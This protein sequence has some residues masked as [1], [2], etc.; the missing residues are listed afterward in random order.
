MKFLPT[1]WE[2][3]PNYTYYGKR[4]FTT[5]ILL[6]AFPY[7]YDVPVAKGILLR[8][9]Y[10]V[11]LLNKC[12]SLLTP[13]YLHILVTRSLWK[14]RGKPATCPEHPGEAAAATLEAR[15]PPPAPAKNPKANLW[16]IRDLQTST[17]ERIKAACQTSPDS[18]HTCMVQK[19][20][21]ILTS[22][23]R[24]DWHIKVFKTSLGFPAFYKIDQHRITEQRIPLHLHL[25]LSHFLKSIFSL[26]NLK[27]QDTTYTKL[28]L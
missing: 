18:P 28:Y 24:K 4:L 7:F 16:S 6:K 1:E 26:I 12:V 9:F 8:S 13:Q 2:N 22:G 10:Q 23:R 25:T 17:L 14:G 5:Y 19:G 3:L 27:K 20:L 11:L 21:W 15:A